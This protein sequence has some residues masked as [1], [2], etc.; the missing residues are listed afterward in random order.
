[1][2]QR[3]NGKLSWA[4]AY[5]LLLES[6]YDNFTLGQVRGQLGYAVTPRDEFGMWIAKSAHGDNGVMGTTPVRLDPISQGNGYYRRTWS[7]MATTTIWAGVAGGHDD[8]VWVFPADPKD[9]HVLVYGADLHMPL[10]DRFAVTG[11]ANFLT[12]TSTGTVDA[13]LGVVF[14]PGRKAMHP[15][16]AFAPMQS[17]ANNPT[18][19]I[20]LKR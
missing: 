18:F 2:F 1:M 16:R 17:V 20:N 10:N 15:S 12:P 3:T 6:Y 4:F 7:T 8:I 5:D 14:Y 19:S 9:K 13:Y 11:A